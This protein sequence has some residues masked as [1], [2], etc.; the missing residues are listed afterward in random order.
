MAEGRCAIG[1]R[2]NVGITR[3]QCTK[4]HSHTHRSASV[5]SRKAK[6]AES[7]ATSLHRGQAG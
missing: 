1:V 7:R 4:N 6:R 2:D 3:P 5:E